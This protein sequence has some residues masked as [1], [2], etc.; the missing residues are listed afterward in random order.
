LERLTLGIKL[1]I[2]VEVKKRD[3]L[4][5]FALRPDLA[6]IF[7]KCIKIMSEQIL[8]NLNLILQR[9]ENACIKSDRNPNEVRLLLATKTVT[10]ER[11]KIA[12][13]SNLSSPFSKFIVFNYEKTSYAQHKLNK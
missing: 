13:M 11:I 10:A 8:N 5:E 1:I 9:I 2:F 4:R 6:V 7:N 12:H 3:E